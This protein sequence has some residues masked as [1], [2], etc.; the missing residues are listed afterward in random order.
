MPSPPVALDCGSQSTRRTWKP[1]I[2]KLVARL[3]AVVVLATPPFWFAI[4]MVTAEGT[5]QVSAM[6]S[7]A[8]DVPRGTFLK[9]GFSMQRV[10]RVPLFFPLAVPVKPRHP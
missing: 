8:Q 7:A 2:A 6:S 9:F 4:A 1:S 5:A 10:P 3:I